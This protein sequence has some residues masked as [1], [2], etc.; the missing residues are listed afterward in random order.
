MNFAAL[1]RKIFALPEPPPPPPPKPPPRPQPPPVIS[2]EPDAPSNMGY[3]SSWFAI[4]SESP[5]A[6]AAALELA[7]VQSANWESGTAF[8]CRHPDSFD[9]RIP[10]FVT[11]P[12]Q[13]WVLAVGVSLP[14]LDA[15]EETSERRQAFFAM[16]DKA[17]ARFA[18]FQFFGTY[19]VCG[20]DC[21]V[22]A[23]NG[24]VER[25]FSIADMQIYAN[26]GAQTPEE[27]TLN[28]MDFGERDPEAAMDYWSEVKLPE[29]KEFVEFGGDGSPETDLLPDEGITM[30]L[31]AAWSVDPSTLQDMGLPASVGF[32][33]Y[34]DCS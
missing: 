5:E 1:L 27:R 23:R 14:F 2:A 4:R 6:V 22:K 24:V 30:A 31:A 19:R 32:V 28:L 33:G 3:K 11:P 12:L 25:L 20:Y 15:L 8:A 9:P 10:I 7:E 16:I 26:I 13:G 21:W 34:M 17:A 29:I 18:E